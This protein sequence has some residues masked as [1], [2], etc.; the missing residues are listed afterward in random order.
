[1][2]QN[3][4]HR[5]FQNYY[6]GHNYL[7]PNPKY[8]ASIKSNVNHFQLR[9]LLQIDQTT[10]DVYFT[11]SYSLWKLSG[12]NDPLGHQLVSSEVLKPDYSPRCFNVTNNGH[13]VIGG[14]MT[15]AYKIFYS[16]I[17]GL[18]LNNQNLTRPQKG[19]FTFYNSQLD[20]S[21][22][23]KLGEMIN[24]SVLLDN[25]GNDQ[26][27]QFKAYVCNNDSSLYA[28]DIANGD[29]ISISSKMR[30]EHD[31]SLNNVMKCPTSDKLL[32]VTGD[33]SSVFLV[34]P[35]SPGDSVVQKLQTNHDS[36]FGISFHPNGNMF[37]VAFQNGHCLLY[38]LRNLSQPLHTINS[39][40]P[41]HQSGAFRACKFSNSSFSD[42][43]VVSEHV[44][45]VHVIDLRNLNDEINNHQVIVFPFALD[46]FGE[47]K[48]K[49]W[50]ENP[51]L[52]RGYGK[53]DDKGLS[54]NHQKSPKKTDPVL[55][56]HYNLPIYDEV[57]NPTSI[58]F[59]VPLVYDYDYLTNVNPKLFKYHTYSPEA[60]PVEGPS[61][62]GTSPVS[63]PF[64]SQP[65]TNSTYGSSF[66]SV[67]NAPTLALGGTASS[68]ISPSTYH[69]AENHIHGEMELSGLDWYGSKLLIGCEN[70]GI[71]SWDVNY[72][73][74]RSFGSFS[75]V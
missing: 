49:Q 12:L 2:P 17:E 30:C 9:D 57:F 4:Y 1:M 68:S 65:Q 70:G 7:N 8:I 71:I 53:T 38:D 48:T 28:L 32:A 62:P 47:Y 19:L 21:K 16:N 63:P 56:S 27:S 10:G 44:G 72:I 31:V 69:N 6:H 59:N 39:T 51:H 26:A 33:T 3:N 11:K 43:L 25:G 74:R 54:P 41:G 14:L 58:Q 75:F 18:K 24:N 66:D 29:R 22:T 20:T 64:D 13:M 36:G 67:Y 42:I 60:K 15:S 37:S 40:R 52:A 45:R 50:Q 5:C 73:A 61:S 35:T 46:Q 34:D 55:E 23:V